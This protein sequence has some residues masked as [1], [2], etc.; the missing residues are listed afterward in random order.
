VNY[1]GGLSAFLREAG[2]PIADFVVRH[3]SPDVLLNGW[4]ESFP[5]E[6]PLDPYVV[7]YIAKEA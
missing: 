6:A 7:L 2:D 3:S 5:V 4:G 1:G